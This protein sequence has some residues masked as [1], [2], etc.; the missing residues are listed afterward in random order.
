MDRYSISQFDSNTF[1]IIDEKEK[2][3]I[4]VCENYN[5]YLDA[6]ER[7]QRIAALLNESSANTI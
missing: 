1:V 2:R 6:E 5:D 7:A 4:C 3:E